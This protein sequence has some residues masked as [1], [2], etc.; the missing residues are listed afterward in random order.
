VKITG[1]YLRRNVDAVL[2]EVLTTGVPV[3][4][5]RKGRLLRIE[6][7]EE[8]S[9]LANLKRRSVLIGDIQDII[10]MDWSSEWSE[11]KDRSNEE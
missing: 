1:N 10:H 11:L 2:D 8:P 3:E 4:I 5:E 6:L 9:K 7:A